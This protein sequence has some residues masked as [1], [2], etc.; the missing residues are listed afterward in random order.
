LAEIPC[1]EAYPDI[2]FSASSRGLWAWLKAMPAECVH[3]DRHSDWS[4]TLLPDIAY[5]RGKKELLRNPGRPEVR[6]CRDCFAKVVRR[7]LAEYPGGVIAF[8]P[9]PEIFSQYFFVDSRDFQAAG[10]TPELASALEARLGQDKRTCA[11]CS[12]EATWLWFSREDVPDLD[13]TDLIARVPGE[14]YCPV[15]GAEKF[16]AALTRLNEANV[17]YMNFVSGDSGAYIWI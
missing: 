14:S 7:E 16:S 15:H 13:E 9:D 2:E 3:L 1:E 6:L 11:D 17:Y 4:V 8:E 5:L 12:R 10:L